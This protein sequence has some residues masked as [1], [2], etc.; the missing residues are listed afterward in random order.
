MLLEL[1][2]TLWRAAAVR[3][4]C[5]SLAARQNLRDISGVTLA[6]SKAANLARAIMRFGETLPYSKFHLKPQMTAGL[7]LCRLH[8]S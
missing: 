1:G 8:G 2:V 4:M 3:R 7:W 6:V 5:R